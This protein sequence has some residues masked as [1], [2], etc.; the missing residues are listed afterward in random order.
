ML[1]ADIV[2]LCQRWAVVLK[3]QF[4]DNARFISALNGPSSTEIKVQVS[5]CLGAPPE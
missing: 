4:A 5:Q 2:L 1:V 3:W